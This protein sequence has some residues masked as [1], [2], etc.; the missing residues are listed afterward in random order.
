M[1]VASEE[2]ISADHHLANDR[3]R[4]HPKA[5]RAIANDEPPSRREEQQPA[6]WAQLDVA[7]DE[8]AL[9]RSDRW[10]KIVA[11]GADNSTWCSDTYHPSGD[12][13]PDRV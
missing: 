2:D 4:R 11:N 9:L 10:A 13:F 7:A 12:A 8:N 1:D 3:D 6:L 5:A